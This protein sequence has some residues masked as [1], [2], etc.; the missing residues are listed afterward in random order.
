[1][2]T[3]FDVNNPYSEADEVLDWLN[4]ARDTIHYYQVHWLVKFLIIKA[5]PKT[6]L[7]ILRKGYSDEY[8]WKK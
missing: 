3:N 8:L 6:S 4:T 1:M 7:F 5:S 2:T